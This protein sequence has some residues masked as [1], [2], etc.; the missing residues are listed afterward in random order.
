M[1]A[2]LT[3]VLEIIVLASAPVGALSVLSHEEM[4]DIAWESEILP[5]LVARY[6]DAT[7]EQLKKAHSFAYGGSVI[8]DLGYYPLGNQLFTNFL[9][10]A[11]TGDFV[12]RMIA[13]ARDL[14]EYAFALGALSHYAADTWG[15]AAVNISE[16]ILY[17]KIRKK[18]G[19][20]VTYED[21][22]EAHLRTEFSFDVLEVAKHRYNA[23]QYH[24]FIGFN[25]SEHLLE[26][27]FQDTYGIPMDMLLHYDDLT[28]ETFRFA[29]AKVIPEM[30][31]VA[32]ATN[33]PEVAHER[34]DA[35]KREFAYHLS[36]TDYERQFG[37]KY[38]R[39]GF[40]ARILGFLLRLIPFGPA[41]ILGYRNPTPKA[42]DYYFRSFD[43]AI[44]QYRQL[45]HQVRAGTLNFPNRNFD[46]GRFTRAGEYV[47]C[48]RT[49]AAWVERMRNDDFRHLTSAARANVLAFFSEGIPANGSIRKSDWEKLERALEEL[50]A[51][52]EEP[53]AIAQ[54]EVNR[55]P[56]AEHDER[57]E[58]F[59]H[60][61]AARAASASSCAPPIRIP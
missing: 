13:D 26:R 1:P 39:P 37:N 30:T 44:E 47:L 15:H 46:T 2:K 49:Y 4:V 6:P 43:R 8:H 5:L 59:L 41:K 27:A 35:A 21:D 22:H 9:H 31:Q 53:N 28:L 54:R 61:A 29:V 14:N 51:H 25:V 34:Q 20:W 45:L 32:L 19:D 38:R 42:E 50:K 16:P 3:L 56:R 10:Y 18:Y 52:P 36:R 7:A 55:S 17:P 58:P 12:A 48:D 40:F 33:R 24:D 60:F 11:R 57:F 23:Q